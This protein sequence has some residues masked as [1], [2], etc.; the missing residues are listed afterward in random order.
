MGQSCRGLA[1]ENEVTAKLLGE[2]S[3]QVALKQ[4]ATAAKPSRPSR[5][6]LDGCAAPALSQKALSEIVVTDAACSSKGQE[7]ATGA[8][9]T[10]SSA[11]NRMHTSSHPC[12]SASMQ[13]RLAPVRRAHCWGILL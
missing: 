11:T 3:Q 2:F 12:E 6:S 4:P 1:G 10:I 7:P 8:S 13:L 5:M 9:A